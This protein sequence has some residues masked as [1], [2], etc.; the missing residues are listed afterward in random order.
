LQNLS[1]F[2]S[3]GFQ[4]LGFGGL[5][6]KVS[7]SIAPVERLKFFQP[8]LL[9][10]SG[11]CHAHTHWALSAA[12]RRVVLESIF[13]QVRLTLTATISFSY[14]GRASTTLLFGMLGGQGKATRRAANGLRR[15]SETKS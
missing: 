10:L 9:G 6:P 11:G 15:H 3:L 4:S 2:Q 12:M 7:S 14:N 13:L 1:G 8:E 5:A